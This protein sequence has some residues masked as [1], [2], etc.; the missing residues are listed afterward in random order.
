MC[1][2]S[3]IA[4]MLVSHSKCFLL[5]FFLSCGAEGYRMADECYDMYRFEFN[6]SHSQQLL[7]C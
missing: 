1:N 4:L 7:T 2:S 6:T 5:L 3:Y